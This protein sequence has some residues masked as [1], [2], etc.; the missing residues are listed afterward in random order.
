MFKTIIWA[1]DGSETADRALPYAKG[2]AEG[3]DKALVVVH[4]KELR[5]GRGGGYPVYADEADL[6]AKIEAQVEEVRKTG[7]A[8][9]LRFATA[10]THGPAHFVAEIAKE[11]GADVIV[12]GTRGHGPISGALLG[13]V[14]QH[15]L[16]DAHCPVLAI[17]PLEPAGTAQTERETVEAA[18]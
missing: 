5:I 13:S 8:V 16:H 18:R 15:L 10:T 11:V 3:R 7:V 4:V 1:T 6:V 14:A 2:L 12:V 17:P 9:T